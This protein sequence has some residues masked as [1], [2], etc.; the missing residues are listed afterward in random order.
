MSGT[1]VSDGAGLVEKIEF[2]GDNSCTV[3]YFGMKL[4]AT[5]RIDKGY[6]HADAGQGLV[7]LFK[8]QNRNTLVGESQ[9]NNA[10]FRK[11]IET[12]VS[13]ESAQ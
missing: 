8:I 10:I 1:Y 12:K 3:T 4:P 11:A 13:T 2:V 5:Y 7:L 9:W 6:I